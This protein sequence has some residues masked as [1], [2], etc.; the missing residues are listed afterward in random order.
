MAVVGFYAAL[1]PAMVRTALKLDNRALANLMVAELFVVAAA[2]IV[3]TRDLKA[4]PAMLAGLVLTPP[5]L[6]LLAAAQAFA[7]APLMLI[8]TTVCGAASALSYRGGLAS[9]NAL[10]PGDR[11]A[12]VASSYFVCCF[13]GNALP[14]VGVA[15]LT[16]AWG[17]QVADRV[18]AAA[19]TALALGAMACT[20][21]FG[22]PSASG[23]G[24]G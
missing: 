8:G 4:R 3:L 15:A 10:A 6:G 24:T 18:F 9:A 22:K 11:R 12:E 19:L 7:S 1:G 16:Q 13:L 21:A 17:A 20:L 5:G 14:I 23:P 2:V